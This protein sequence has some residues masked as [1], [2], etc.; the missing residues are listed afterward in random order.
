M[1]GAVGPV[2]EG[3]EEP[4]YD[5]TTLALKTI[6]PEAIHGSMDFA[7]TDC[8]TC[9]GEGKSASSFSQ[10]HTG[11]DKII[12]TADGTR[13]SDAITVTVD[14]ATFDGSMLNVQF[15]AVE[16]TDLAD[17]DVASI[18]PTILVGLY[19][20]D[21]K[22]FIIGPHERLIDDNGDGSIN[23]DDSR[24]LEAEVGVE[25]PRIT[26]VSSDGGMWEVNVDLSNWADYIADGTVT[27]VEIGVMPALES[28][29]GVALALVAPS[30]TFDL[31]A[32][33]FDDEFYAP[34]VTVADG[35]D[36]C[37]EA[38]AT[39]FHSPS[40]GGNIVVCRMCHIT[41]AG[42]SHL[43]LQSR[44]ID[45]YVHA[46]HSFQAFDISGIDFV[47]PVEA[48]EYEHHVGFPYPTHGIT[49]CESCHLPGTNNV[50]DQA[51]SLPGLLSASGELTGW[52]R[53]IEE[54]PATITGPATRAC[55]GCHRAVLIKEDRA[56]DLQ[57]LNQHFEQ[58]GYI[59]EA[60]EDASGNLLNV[61]NEI[62][63]YFK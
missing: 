47:D 9:H 6:I 10:I 24:T 42:G 21:T 40:Y 63:S 18:T 28:A 38:L 50:P 41:K 31:G 22:D 56:G 35:C 33:A 14:S 48:M 53:N 12:Y 46:I 7:T 23:G 3:E 57:I 25:H 49:N 13:Y 2:P 5:T 20:W 30:R 39:N 29:D 34:I 19:G 43:E 62:M 36:T 52:D 1:T 32:N 37:H 4:S 45:S 26:T 54:M 15:S 17:L 27:R 51:K 58:G 44:S 60:G 61:I 8:T 11:Y 59:V 16:N 55:G